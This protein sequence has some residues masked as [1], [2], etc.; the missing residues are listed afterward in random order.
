MGKD[1]DYVNMKRMITNL[2][3]PLLL[4]EILG[5]KSG[6]LEHSVMDND[7]TGIKL[8][9]DSNVNANIVSDNNEEPSEYDK[10][11]LQQMLNDA[12]GN[13]LPTV[14]SINLIT[15]HLDKTVMRITINV[16]LDKDQPA[17][18]HISSENSVPQLKYDNFLEI[19]PINVQFFAAV[20]KSFNKE[21]MSN[22][23]N[24]AQADMSL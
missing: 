8:T 10:T 1:T 23:K 9:L 14:Q 4:E 13:I 15:V 7:N 5:D 18:I 3:N 20:A 6:D 12:V 21:L 17:S 22:F 24:A 19:S 2:R 16:M 11:N